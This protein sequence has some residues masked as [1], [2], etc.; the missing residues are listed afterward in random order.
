[1]R[2]ILLPA[3]ALG[4]MSSTALAEPVTMTEA[5]MDGVTAA[6]L[7]FVDATKLVEIAEVI[8][9]TAAINKK[10]LVEQLVD[11]QGYFADADAG[12]NCFGGGCEAVTYAITDVN[13]LQT[14]AVVDLLGGLLSV[15]A[16]LGFATSASGS[17]AAASRQFLELELGLFD[18]VTVANE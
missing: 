15:T 12:A 3:L 5:E 10:K 18:D 11:V 14:T 17:E 8:N 6:G 13:S 4:A 16:P 9:K 7:A 2:R 1:M